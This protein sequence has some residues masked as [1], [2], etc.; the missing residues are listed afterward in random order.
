MVAK[1][2]RENMWIKI[3]II[4]LFLCGVGMWLSIQPVQKHR[5]SIDV[6]LNKRI[7]DVL[8]ANDVVQDDILIQ[9]RRERNKK[10]AQWNEF[11]KTVKL[12]S[13]KNLKSLEVSFRSIARSLKIGLSKVDNVD[14]STTYKFYS[15]TKNY[16]NITFVSRNSSKG[17]Y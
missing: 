12:R 9:Y 6:A 13:G 10:T 16:Y 7:V 14:G 5:L 15:P 1:K 8:V 17:W 11:Y 2:K 3:Y 4:L